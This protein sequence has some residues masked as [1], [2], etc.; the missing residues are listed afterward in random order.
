MV[1]LNPEKGSKTGKAFN[2]R[3]TSLINKIKDATSR[4]NVENF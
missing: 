1:L 4:W 3:I 2:P